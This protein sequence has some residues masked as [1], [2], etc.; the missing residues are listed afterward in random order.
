[1]ALSG[2]EV[3]SGGNS[4]TI[5]L[6][7]SGHGYLFRNV[8]ADQ[9]VEILVGSAFPRMIGGSEVA[10]QREALL[11]VFVTVEFGAVVE[12]DRLEAGLV[13]LNCTQ[14][15]LRHGS[16]GPR[17]QLFDNSEAG[18]TFNE[19]E[20][21]VMAIAADHSVSFPMA[22]LRTGFHH[23]GPLRDMALAWQNSA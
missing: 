5:D 3:Q 7:N 15:S 22:E 4:V 21:A 18:F 16:G 10:L 11:E 6:R 2:S 14:G 9:T 19:S 13:F 20:N 12:S 8:L 17:L 1:M 23:G